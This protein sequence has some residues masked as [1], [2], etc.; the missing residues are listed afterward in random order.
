MAGEEEIV[1]GRYGESVS[2]ECGRVAGKGQC[3]LW[4]DTVGHDVSTCSR[5]RA[6]GACA[7][8]W[9]TGQGSHADSAAGTDSSRRVCCETHISGSFFMSAMAANG[10]PKFEA[11]PQKSVGHVVSFSDL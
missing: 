11:G 3:E 8:G 5:N 6:Y 4:G 1:L 2:H 10:I 7:S 9:D